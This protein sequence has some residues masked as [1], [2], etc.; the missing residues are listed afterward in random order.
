M[1]TTMSAL[2]LR[3]GYAFVAQVGDSRVYRV[4]RGELLQITEDHTLVNYR[5]KQGLITAEEARLSS[6]KNVITRAV[7]HKDYVQVDTFSDHAQPGDRYFLCTDGFHG[8]TP[9]D[10]D[11]LDLVSTPMIERGVA[12]A[13]DLANQLGGRDN[14]TAVLVKVL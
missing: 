11:V 13:I 5:L 3:A 14:I 12:H 9:P 10:K 1:S 8:Y 4:R 7:G 2:L 6:A